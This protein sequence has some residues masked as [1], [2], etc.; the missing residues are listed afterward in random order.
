PVHEAL[1]QPYLSNPS[2]GI[3]VNQAPPAPI[4]EVPPDVVPTRLGTDIQ[5]VPGYWGW[6]NTVGFIWV[7]GIWRDPPPEMRWLPGYWARTESGAGWV[8]GF[9]PPVD[10]DTL[11]YLPPPPPSREQGPTSNPPGPDFFWVP[12]CW[13]FPEGRYLWRPGFWSRVQP[14]W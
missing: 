13:I 5:W 4:Q 6:Q 10:M 7:S 2:P 3:E 1:A 12:G 11:V 14:D 9:W 8:P